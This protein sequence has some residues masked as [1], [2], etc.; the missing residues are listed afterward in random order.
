MG[1]IKLPYLNVYKD[2][3]GKWRA[4]YRRAGQRITVPGDIGSAEF[5]AAYQRI[6]ATFEHDGKSRSGVGT[7]GHLLETYYAAPEFNQLRDSTKS[8]YKRHLEPMRE[9][10]AHIGLSGITKK[11][12]LAWRDS[13]Q[14]RPT[15]ANGAMAVLKILFNF[16]ID[17]DM[18][19]TNPVLRVKPLKIESD[20]WQP[21]PADK[22][23][24]FAKASKGAPR[25]A[26]YLALYTGQRRADVLAMRW[27]AITDGGISVKQEKTNAMVW[28]PLHPILAAELAKVDRK[29]LTIVQRKD[30]RPYTD[31]GFGSVWNREV[32]RLGCA[33][34]PFHGLRKN[35][36]NRMFEAGCTP[37][38]VQAI[39]GH[40]T[41]EMVEHYGKGANQKKLA[42]QAMRRLTEGGEEDKA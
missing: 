1:V 22:L 38:Q 25:S 27:D 39:T 41:L 11:V 34:L 36:T 2:R 15:K 3:H 33:R 28:V 35:A 42:K 4:Y 23:A 9:K 31:D 16:A 40:A 5:I 6:H 20:G 8:E 37:Q 32:H 24:K 29:G 7:F 14:D 30:G 12:A 19:E 26:F 10:L 21:W 13:L 17:R 18:V